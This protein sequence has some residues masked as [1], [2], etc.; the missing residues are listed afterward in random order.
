MLLDSGSYG[1]YVDIKDYIFRRHTGLLC[2]KPVGSLADLD[3]ALKSD[4]LSL[5]I[6]SHHDHSGTE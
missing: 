4:S 1:Q 6:E 5:L 2:Q 3:L